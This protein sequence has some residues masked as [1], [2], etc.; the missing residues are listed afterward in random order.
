MSSDPE[1]QIELISTLSVPRYAPRLKPTPIPGANWN[2][3]PL[4]CLKINDEWVSHLLGVMTALDQPD[5]WLGT[6]EQIYAAR[7]QVNE[8]MVA[9]MSM[10]DDCEVQFRIEDCDLQWRESEDEEWISLG[11]VCGADG[12]QGPPG[13]T[14]ERGETGETGSE[15]PQ[16]PP[17][18]TGPTGATGPA[19]ADGSDCDCDCESVIHYDTPDNPP[20]TD[21]DQSSC[22]IAGSLAEYLRAMEQKAIDAGEETASVGAK[23]L[24]LAAAIVAAIWTGGA[25]WPLIVA[26]AGALIDFVV[27]HSESQSVVDDD[28]FWEEMA[29]SIYCALKPDKDITD[30]KKSA[31]VAAIRATTYTTGAYDAPL[32]YGI[33]ADFLDGLPV[34]LIRGQAVAGIRSVF[35]CSGCDDCPDDSCN[36]DNWEGNWTGNVL[37]IVDD[38]VTIEAVWDGTR[39]IVAGTTGDPDLCCHVA[40]G[41][42]VGGATLPFGYITCGNAIDG[43]NIV[44]P[45]GNPDEC[46]WFF[47]VSGS[48]FT[49]EITFTA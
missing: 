11:N 45:L 49:A 8:I 4:F 39:Y 22:N 23:I 28:Q 12:S 6:P 33:I 9:L 42:T 19:G 37:S 10:C 36:L 26:A 29:C 18:D 27:S 40:V 41:F 1:N 43:A 16:G 3:S 35:D 32:F 17:G 14:G 25:A 34:E 46:N 5:T 44:F 15:G 30:A 47:M 38:V 21:D 7:Q 24:T 31:I 48:P 2:D 13:E 20:E